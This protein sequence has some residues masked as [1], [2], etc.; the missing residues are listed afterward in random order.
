MLH[1]HYLYKQHSDRYLTHS[2]YRYSARNAY[3]GG[4][5]KSQRTHKR[6]QNAQHTIIRRYVHD[7][8]TKHGMQNQ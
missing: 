7:F 8:R 5:L 6:Q 2:I 3:D 1:A 4:I